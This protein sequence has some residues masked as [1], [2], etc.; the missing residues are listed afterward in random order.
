MRALPRGR[1]AAAAAL[2]ALGVCTVWE[3]H[4][5]TGHA[6]ATVALQGDHADWNELRG[7]GA[8][9][10][11]EPQLGWARADYA[12][13]TFLANRESLWAAIVRCGARDV[14]LEDSVS[15]PGDAPWWRYRDTLHRLET[16]APLRHIATLDGTE[17]TAPP[18]HGDSAAVAL[19]RHERT[20]QDPRPENLLPGWAL[21]AVV[22][23]WGGAPAVGLWTPA[24]ASTC[25]AFDGG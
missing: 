18:P 9:S 14:R 11:T 10:S 23:A 5:G 21:R 13:G 15:G 25:A 20:E 19:L 7:W 17:M 4:H 2:L 8:A 12:Q 16:A 22:P 1:G 3:F 6:R 24:G